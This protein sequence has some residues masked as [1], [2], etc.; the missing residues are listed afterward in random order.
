MWWL[1]RRSRSAS[2][3]PYSRG[4]RRMNVRVSAA[5]KSQGISWWLWPV[6][7]LV[8]LV[9]LY[10][11]LVTAGRGLYARNPV[12]T[13]QTVT[14]KGG[15]DTA[16]ACIKAVIRE[17]VNLF[18]FDLKKIRGDFFSR[19]LGAGYRDLKL[20]RKLP[21]TMQVEFVD[22]VPA[23]RLDPRINLVVDGE[24]MIFLSGR[25]QSLPLLQGLRGTRPRPGSEADAATRE[26]LLVLD[27]WG[28]AGVAQEAILSSVDITG[29]FAGF[30]N[31]M[32][33]VLNEGQT[34]VLLWWPRKGL[35]DQA[36]RAD[37]KGRMEHLRGILARL[38]FE[39]RLPKRINLAMEKYREHCTVSPAAV[40]AAN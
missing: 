10:A 28:E 24:G 3:R 25:P 29:N 7:G 12:F 15:D 30:P 36:G 18:A 39:G 32:R 31:D 14:I 13:I 22:R 8:V 16:H 21:G 35:D 11:A 23:A 1:Q 4:P 5:R 37:L 2:N 33:L 9:L 20:T 34:E 6:A 17:G 38:R 27:V 40:E 26:A 19:P